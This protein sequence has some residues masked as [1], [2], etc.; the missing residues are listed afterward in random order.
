[1]NASSERMTDDD[2]S[3]S[4]STCNLTKKVSLLTNVYVVNEL[5][6]GYIA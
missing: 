1:M 4:I 3:L 5:N 2:A 6:Y